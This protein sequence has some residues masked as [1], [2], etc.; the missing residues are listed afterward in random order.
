MLI[1]IVF[2]NS[3]TFFSK[4][5]M[6][7]NI[8]E[9][10]KNEKRKLEFHFCSEVGMLGFVMLFQLLPRL[11]LLIAGYTHFWHDY[12]YFS[13]SFQ[14]KELF[15]TASIINKK[16]DRMESEPLNEPTFHSLSLFFPKALI[17]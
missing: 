1:C 11:E 15:D 4:K 12:H 14:R 10:I 2:T 5:L 9:Q 3:F 13:I 16:M 6:K 8:T 7:K 17:L